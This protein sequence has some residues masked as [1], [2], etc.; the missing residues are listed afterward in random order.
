MKTLLPVALLLVLMV[1]PAFA[2]TF[3]YVRIIRQELLGLHGCLWTE[4]QGYI[5]PAVERP[6][7]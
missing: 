2:Q 7:L 6:K 1:V 5:L 3:L 4:V